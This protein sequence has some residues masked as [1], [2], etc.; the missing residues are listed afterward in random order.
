MSV[1]DASSVNAPETATP[2][3]AGADEYTVVAQQ[4]IIRA[5]KSIN[6]YVPN[7]GA[8]YLIQA[9][10]GSGTGNKTDSGVMVAVILP[11][12]TFVLSPATQV[13][14]MFNPYEYFIDAD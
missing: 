13:R 1:V 9:P 3:T 14:N 12:E 11:G 8:I 6:P 4:I 5:V 2:G 10:A 7:T